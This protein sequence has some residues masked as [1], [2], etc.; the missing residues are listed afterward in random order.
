[1]GMVARVVAAAI[2][3]PR[4]CCTPEAD[5]L[6]GGSDDLIRWTARL[7]AR[8]PH[9]ALLRRAGAARQAGRPPGEGSGGV[10]ADLQPHARRARAPARARTP[11]ARHPAR[12]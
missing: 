2:L 6:V 4:A 10:P 12:R 11:G 7:G 9:A 5:S 3:S 8:N 1:M